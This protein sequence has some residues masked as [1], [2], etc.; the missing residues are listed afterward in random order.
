MSPREWRAGAIGRATLSRGTVRLACEAV[1][2]TTAI[3]EQMHRNIA[4]GA[5]P[6]GTEP[7]GGAGGIAGAVYATIRGVTRA[8]GGALDATLAALAPV[9]DGFAQ[10]DPARDALLAAV[11]GVIGDHLAATGN[12]LALPM[13]LRHEGQEL[14]VGREALAQQIAKPRSRVVLCVHGLCMHDGQWTRNGHHHGRMLA[15]VLDATLL[16]LRYNSGLHIADNGRALSALLEQLASAWP[17]R[18][19]G[20]HLVGHSMGG[21]VCRSA[22]HFAELDAHRWR[23]LLQSLACLGSPH[24]GAPLERAGNL[25]NQLALLSPYLAPLARIGHLRSAGIADLRDGNLTEC[26]PQRAARFARPPAPHVPL[27]DGVR[28]VAAAASLAKANAPLRERLLGDGLVPVRSALGQ[29]P[30]GTRSLAF[31]PEDRLVIH[32]ANHWDLLGAPDVARFLC[33]RLAG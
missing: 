30:D 6:V 5:L 13:R 32:G 22:I 7:E 28:S 29:D 26:A 15:Q 9:L 19:R 31:A 33:A 1:V 18:L 11:N 10:D 4:R 8:V 12:P 23:L 27:P 21:L 25:V 2:Q 14:T 24:L 16:H 17:V 3:V 20:L